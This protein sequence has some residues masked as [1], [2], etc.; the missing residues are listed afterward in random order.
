MLWA[1]L[2]WATD[3]IQ[4][5]PP[6]VIGQ[7]STLSVTDA[8]G[9]PRA[10][11]T[12]RITYRK[13]LSTTEDRAIGLTDGAG[14]LRWTPE[15]AGA[16]ELAVNNDRTPISIGWRFPPAATLLHLSILSLAG[17]LFAVWGSSRRSWSP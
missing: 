14:Q 6:P 15:A 9:L 4:L 5:E 11:R 13:R 1:T 8:D 16:A 2:A 3:I 7:E 17:A 10:G 12:V